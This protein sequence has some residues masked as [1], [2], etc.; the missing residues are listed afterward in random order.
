MT[1]VIKH[2]ED[3]T[4]MRRDAYPDW[5]ELADALYWQSLGNDAPMQAYLA[6]CAAVKAAIPKLEQTYEV[7]RA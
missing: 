3:Y 6:K 2:V 5:R 1:T 7:T 4:K